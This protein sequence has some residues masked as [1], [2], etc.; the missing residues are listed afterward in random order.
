L[1]K[2]IYIHN[3]YEPANFPRKPDGEDRFY[4]YGF[5]SS[6]ARSFKRYSPDFT[7]E[8]WRLDGYVDKYYEKVVQ[9]VKFKIFPGIRIGRWG[10]FSW[11][12]IRELRR[13]LRKNKSILFV[14][15]VHTWLTYQIAFFFGK[16][17]PLTCSHHGDWS[18][19]FKAKK[20][21][22][23]RWLKDF[24]EMQIEKVMLKRVDYFFVGDFFQIPYLRR[25]C[26]DINYTIFSSGL[27]IRKMTPVPK[28]AAREKLGWK[29]NKK[30]I[31][32]V[33]KLYELKQPKELIDMWREIKEEHPEVELVVIGNYKSDK[34]YRYAVE[35][36]AIVLGRILNRELNVYYSAADVYVLVALRDD[37]FGGT[38]IAPLEALACNTPVVSYSLR[39]YIGDNVHELGEVPDSIEAYKAAIKKVLFNGTSYKNMR[40]SIE[41]YYSR[42]V[43]ASKVRKVYD[44]LLIKYKMNENENQ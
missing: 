38:G 39:N 28:E 22:G 44:E 4:T 34:Y 19:F 37:F 24:A 41:K 30:Y 11:K 43:I 31:L 16:N 36:G 23:L 18:P 40:E 15:H 12:F 26:P 29:K 33:G 8:M 5:G 1:K 7:V 25:A 27:D 20:R 10:E 32:Y 3:N 35:S 21:K 17:Y 9:N 42:R 6:L 2:V 14:S 13:E